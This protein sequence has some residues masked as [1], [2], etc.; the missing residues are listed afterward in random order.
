M[1][2]RSGFRLESYRY[3]DVPYLKDADVHRRVLLA[4][5]LVEQRRAEGDERRG[6]DAVQELAEVEEPPV[7]RQ[8]RRELLHALRFFI[9]V[10]SIEVAYL[11]YAFGAFNDMLK[12]CIMQARSP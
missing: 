5:A 7:P 1:Y 6:A 4:D 12:F 9:A 11:E 2:L 3:E 10:T 8:R